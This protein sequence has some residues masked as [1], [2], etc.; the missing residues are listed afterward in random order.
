VTSTPG[1]GTTFSVYLPV[2]GE[3]LPAPAPHHD[4]PKGNGERILLVDDD[5]MQLRIVERMLRELNYTVTT[6]DSGEEAVR[7][8]RTS[9]CDLVVL[10]MQMGGIDGAETFRR[11]RLHNPQQ[12]AVILSGYAGTERV[13]SALAGGALGFIQKP[14]QVGTLGTMIMRALRAEMIA[15]KSSVSTDVS[16]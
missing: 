9:R 10:D 2:A 4:V 5:L 8:L 6:V 14:V 11:M 7:M 12:R 13:A 1:V 3:V 15:S 16:R